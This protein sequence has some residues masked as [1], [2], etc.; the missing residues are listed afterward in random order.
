MLHLSDSHHRQKEDDSYSDFI[1]YSKKYLKIIKI[2]SILLANIVMIKSK[3]SLIGE[4][5]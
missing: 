5:V 1:D 2:I 4:N 3:K